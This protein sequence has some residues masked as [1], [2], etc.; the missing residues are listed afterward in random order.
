MSVKFPPGFTNVKFTVALSAAEIFNWSPSSSVINN[1]FAFHDAVASSCR[2]SSSP[3]KNSRFRFL[4]D[5]FTAL[6]RA[7]RLANRESLFFWVIGAFPDCDVK[8]SH[9][10]G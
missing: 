10:P 2:I 8:G 4:S 5:F 9:F 1:T 3:A 6:R 7:S